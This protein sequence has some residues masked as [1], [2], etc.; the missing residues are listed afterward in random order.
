MAKEYDRSLR[1]AEQLHRELALL[2]HDEVDDP[3]VG[4]LTIAEVEVSRDLSHAK[5]FYS[6][7]AGSG[8]CTETQAGLERAAGFLRRALGQRLYLRAIPRLH[9][10]YDDTQER[11]SYLSVLI[12][13]ARARDR[14]L[15]IE[16][17]DDGLGPDNENQDSQDS[18]DNSQ[19]GR[20]DG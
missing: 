12:D 17:G 9:F 6:M 13:D 5:V 7:L 16:T 11:G 2:I 3:R 14:A 19:G 1:I 8:A 15:R 20:D 18:Q 10:V 4:E